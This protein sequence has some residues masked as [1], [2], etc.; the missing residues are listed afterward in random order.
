MYMVIIACDTWF[1]SLTC[2]YGGLC[3]VRGVEELFVI[4]HEITS[5]PGRIE[6]AT[7]IKLVHHL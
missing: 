4:Q 5:L 2:S 7:V 3:M 6:F 1:E